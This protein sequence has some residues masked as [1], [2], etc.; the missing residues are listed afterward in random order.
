MKRLH[1]L[2]GLGT[3]AAGLATAFALS[4]GAQ[5]A[6][7]ATFAPTADAFVTVAH[8]DKNY[9]ESTTLRVDNSPC[10]THSYLKFD[11]SG[12]SGTVTNATLHIYAKT[13]Q[14]YGYDTHGTST[15]WSETGVTYANA[16]ALGIS[17]G[18]GGPA[19]GGTWTQVDVTSLVNG[20][21]T[22]SFGLDTPDATQL[23]MGSRE[24]AHPPYLT[25]TTSGSTTTTGTTGTTTGTTTTTTTTTN[26]PPPTGPC[27]SKVGQTS[28]ITKVMWIVMENKDYSSIYDNS[29][30]PYETQLADE[31]GLATNYHAA[32]H[33]S[34]PNYIAL[35]SGS[36][37]GITD[38]SDPSSH[39]LDVQ[40][41]F[42]Q[43]YPSAKSYE[44]SM[45]SD[46]A[47][48]SSGEYAVRHNPWAYYVNG[49]VGNQRDECNAND[50]PTPN[51]ASAGGNLATDVATGALPHFSFVTPGLCNDMHDCS[52]SVGDAYLAALV[53]VILAG[54]DYTSGHLAVVIT[55]DENGGASGNQV[56]TAVISPFTQPGTKD[57][58]DYTHYSLLRTTEEILGYS[59]LGNAAGAS[60]MRAAFGW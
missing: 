12:L 23:S 6:S 21:G 1:A 56:Y 28:T 11:V 35:T 17:V 48:S 26:P 53:P 39:P 8:P 24:S 37:Q 5:G 15:D 32:S 14:S 19:E 42:H 36:T 22:V 45:P 58:T 54:P 46:C 25:V 9:G 38:D 30:A 47:Q 27:G 44:E 40:S 10:C 31:C 3:L 29:S 34:L 4:G 18:R 2:I 52:V 55:Y 51:P 20:D 59:L 33:P 50:V 41:I 7:T 13:S 60:D 49:S 16:P 57:G 43:A